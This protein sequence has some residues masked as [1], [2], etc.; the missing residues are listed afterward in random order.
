MLSEENKSLT[1]QPV[2]LNYQDAVNRA[3]QQEDHTELKIEEVNTQK[4]SSDGIASSPTSST[5]TISPKPSPKSSRQKNKGQRSK[6]LTNVR[7]STCKGTPL[8]TP[9]IRSFVGKRKNKASSPDHNEGTQDK[10]LKSD[11]GVS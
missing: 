3:P 11:S 4:P 8:S 5:K 10:F 7:A 9:D 6:S 1:S 2:P